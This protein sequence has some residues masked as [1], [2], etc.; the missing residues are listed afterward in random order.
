M[1]QVPYALHDSAIPD[2][3]VCKDNVWD[4]LHSACSVAQALTDEEIDE[5]L[6]LQQAGPGMGPLGEGRMEKI[7]GY[8][9]LLDEPTP[10]PCVIY[11]HCS[12]HVVSCARLLAF[13]KLISW[14]FTI[15]SVR[16]PEA[17]AW[18]GFLSV[19]C[20]YRG[21][22]KDEGGEGDED[23][24]DGEGE[25][26]QGGRMR[27]RRVAKASRKAP[28]LTTSPA[29]G[30]IATFM[31]E[32]LEGPRLGRAINRSRK[33]SSVPPSSATDGAA[34]NGSGGGGGSGGS[35]G[36]GGGGGLT[37][38]RSVDSGGNGLGGLPGGGQ[39]AVMMQRS[40]GGRAMAKERMANRMALGGRLG[41]GGPGKRGGRGRGNR[42][43]G[44]IG[45]GLS[46]A[47]EALLGMGSE[48]LDDDDLMVSRSGLFSAH[49]GHTVV[50]LC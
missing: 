1:V 8:Y 45:R 11:N 27:S 28:S 12:V 40:R 34:V 47:A 33:P 43:R 7:E 39:P 10:N 48:V 36:N 4:R 16:C 44:R 38:A 17:L 21:E 3:W 6:A 31:P 32:Q 24:D 20:S 42:G 9:S 23:N 30:R 18:N 5:I 14:D 46:E 41:G 15:L 22:E 35:G 37:T 50:Y 19:V 49:S 2:D 26:S 13:R 29:R 25:Y